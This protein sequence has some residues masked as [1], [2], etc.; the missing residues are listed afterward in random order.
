[1]REYCTPGSVRGVPGNRHPY[2]GDG[3][4]PNQVIQIRLP[5]ILV[6]NPMFPPG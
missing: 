2:R 3:I 4:G 1:M 6:Q 5:N